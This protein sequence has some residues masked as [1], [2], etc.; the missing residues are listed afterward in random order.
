MF[1]QALKPQQK[2]K[3]NGFNLAQK[4][5]MSGI[6]AK[7]DLN[8][9]QILVLI[10]LSSHYNPQKSVVFPS[11]EFLAKNLNISERSVIRAIS[12]LVKKRIIVKSKQG[13]NNLYAFTPI[14]FEALGLSHAECQNVISDG[15]KMSHKQYNNKYKNNNFDFQKN[16]NKTTSENVSNINDYQKVKNNIEQEKRINQTKEYLNEQKNIK[17][18]SPL[19]FSKD[20]AIKYIESMGIFGKN[21]YFVIKLKEKWNL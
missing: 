19:D 2:F 7:F 18:G 20:E 9:T 16:W 11:Q 21:S 13:N 1:A 15:D 3:I 4:I 5:Y 14:F 17:G 10:G 12:E 6:A 8:P